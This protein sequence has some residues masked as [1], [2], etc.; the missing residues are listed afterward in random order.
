[1]AANHDTGVSSRIGPFTIWALT[2]TLQRRGRVSEYWRQILLDD[3]LMRSVVMV[4]DLRFGGDLGGYRA[5]LSTIPVHSVS[6]ATGRDHSAIAGLIEQPSFDQVYEF[7]NATSSARTIS[8]SVST[9][10]IDA[11]KL[12][13]SGIPLFGYAEISLEPTRRANGVVADYDE[14]LVLLRGDIGGSGGPRFGALRTRQ[15]GTRQAETLDLQ[16]ADPRDS[17]NAKFPPWIVDNSRFE[18]INAG[19]IGERL[20]LVLNGFVHIPAVR[21]TTAATGINQQW[22]FAHDH[23]WSVAAGDG[24]AVNGVTYPSGDATYGWAQSSGTDLRGI[25]FEQ[26]TF[27][28]NA[29]VWEDTDVVHVSTTTTNAPLGVVDSIEYL[30]RR[31]S[32]FGNAGLN[33]ELFSTAAA[34]FASG[35]QPQILTNESSTSQSCLKW[36]EDTFLPSFPMLSM[37]WESGQYGPILTDFRSSPVAKFVAGTYPLFDRDTLQ[38]ELP[39][40]EIQNEFVIRYDYDPMLDIYRQVIIRGAE[41]SDICAYSQAIAGERHRDPIESAYINDADLATYVMDW[42]VA[43]RAL[44]SYYL[45]YQCAPAVWLERRRGDTV[46]LTDDDF[47]WSEQPAT[48]ERITMQRSQCVVGLRVWVRYIDLGGSA[49]S[50]A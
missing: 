3:P 16:I 34:R 4:V 49:L 7:D 46:L 13:Q 27:T 31:F 45:E 32:P 11:A 47:G 10:F 37:V 15:N 48:I 39:K 33:D 36:V 17:V 1:M 14:R 24:V 20:P 23:Q 28:N 6:T 25:P 9:E 8:L 43:H 41:N 19:W 21:T 30:L 22:V 42:L 50:Y 40:S 12:V 2:D 38:E 29:T 44:P 35:S 18:T 5:R 26:I